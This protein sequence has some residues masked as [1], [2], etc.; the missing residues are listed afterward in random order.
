MSSILPA[1]ILTIWT[2]FF[3]NPIRSLLGCYVD[4]MGAWFYGLFFGFMAGIIYVHSKNV[5]G[6]AV[7]LILLGTFGAIIF[8]MYIGT[9]LGL[10][11]AFAVTVILYKGFITKGRDF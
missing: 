4:V 6:V 8:P 5:V 11:G 9:F 2:D 3:D 1:L 7:F 10:V